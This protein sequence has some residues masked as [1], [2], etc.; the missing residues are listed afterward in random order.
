MKWSFLRNADKVDKTIFQRLEK[1][2]D[3][4]VKKQKLKELQASAKD[5]D[6]YARKLLWKILIPAD[7]IIALSKKKV[8]GIGFVKMLGKKNFESF[9]G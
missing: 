9:L 1:S 3:I 6:E 4:W 5:M 2:S 7:D 8:P